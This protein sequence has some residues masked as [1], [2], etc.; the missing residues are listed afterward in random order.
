MSPK[1]FVYLLHSVSAQNRPYVGLTSGVLSRLTDHNAGRCHH[2]A[3]HRP[4][5]LVVAVEFANEDRALAF[6]RYLKIRF[7]PRLRE[8]PFRLSGEPALSSH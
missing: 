5:Q 1:R 6:E 4:W 8:A 7:R 3:R 2:T